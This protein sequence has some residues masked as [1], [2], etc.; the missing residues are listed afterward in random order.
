MKKIDKI[1][2]SFHTAIVFE[3]L[4]FHFKGNRL[5]GSAIDRV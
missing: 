2:G 3:K 1:K 4:N 5:I